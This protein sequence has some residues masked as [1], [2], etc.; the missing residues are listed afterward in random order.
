M[1]VIAVAVSQNTV[2]HNAFVLTTAVF[3][4]QFKGAVGD[5]VP[6]TRVK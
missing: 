3:F 1:T 6:Y 4:M 2:S 5:G